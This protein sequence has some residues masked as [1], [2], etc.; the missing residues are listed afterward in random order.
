MLSPCPFAILYYDGP[1]SQIQVEKSEEG[2][3]D[4]LSWRCFQSHDPTLGRII[5]DYNGIKDGLTEL[6]VGTFLAIPTRAGLEDYIARV[7]NSNV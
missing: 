4:L 6:K 7:Y 3:L 1:V 2:R 5:A